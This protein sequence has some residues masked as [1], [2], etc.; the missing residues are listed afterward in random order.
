MR[1]TLFP[2]ACLALLPTIAGAEGLKIVTDIAPIGSLVDMVT[3][4]LSKPEVLVS[5]AASPHGF[6]LKP[7]QAAA[8]QEADAVFWVSEQL[9]PWME[10]P[11]E[12]LASGAIAVELADSAPVLRE[13]REEAEHDDHEGHAEE[14]AE[15][16]HAHE[17]GH[18]H[19]GIDPHLWLD[20]QNAT[21]WLSVIAENLSALDPQNAEVYAQNAQTAAAALTALGAELKADL[22]PVSGRPFLVFHDA[23]QYFTEAYALTSVGSISL[24]DAAPTSAAHLSEIQHHVEETGATCAFSEPQFD[25]RLI[26]AVSTS[27][28]V[29]ELDPLGTNQAPGPDL[30][31]ATLRAMAA[32]I[33][34]CL[35]E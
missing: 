4:G 33:K 9:T 26:A 24:G 30:Y 11:L 32:T 25:P 5:G 18:D 1:H 19:S 31:S 23:Y 22:A 21:A 2:V 6:A 28:K 16:K 17:E 20:P 8:L 10:A 15:E 13:F 35:T 27:L 14:K 29:A 12:A 34:D 3:N 7:S